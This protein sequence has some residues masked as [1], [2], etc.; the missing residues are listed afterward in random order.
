MSIDARIRELDRRHRSLE[1]ELRDAMAHPS[2]TDSAIQAIKRR[3]L[4]IKEEI[5]LLKSRARPAA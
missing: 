2:S 1:T 4:H 5:E 3:K